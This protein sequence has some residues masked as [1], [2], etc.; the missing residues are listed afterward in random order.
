MAFCEG[1]SA[2]AGLFI[3]AGLGLL[4]CTGMGEIPDISFMACSS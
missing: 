1:D 4:W 2:I 3:G